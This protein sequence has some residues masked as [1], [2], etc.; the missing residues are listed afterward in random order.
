[1]SFPNTIYGKSGWEKVQ[2]STQKHKIGTR[3]SFDDGRAFRYSEVG[4][5]DI[6]AGAVVQAPAAVGEHDVDLAI[7]TAAS[8]V[9]EVTVT[10]ENEATT[11]NQYKDG[12]LFINDGV[13][14]EGHVYR[15][16]SNPVASGTATCAI[17]LYED[18][19]TV[20]ALTNG[21]HLAGLAV[22]PYSNV[23]ISP[24]T[25][26]NV[27]IGV[28]PRLLTTNYYGWIQTWGPAAVLANAAGVVGEHVRVGGTSTAGGTED[29]DRD[30]TAENEQA[31]GVQMQIA[32]TS[33]A[34][35]GLI[36][37]QIT[38]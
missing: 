19:P 36:Y 4:A 35:Y 27:A 10:L 22:N 7:A 3:M 17:T 25:V 6:A 2:T 14:G 21:T 13:T 30:G 38:P 15:I 24:T 18:D 31:I 23:I 16:K 9:T 29:L 37:L 12:Y 1:M 32:P 11:L 8:G 34:D 5:A 33:A 20:T 26:T 28:A